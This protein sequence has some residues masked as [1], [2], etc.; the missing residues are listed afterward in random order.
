MMVVVV[1]PYRY[2]LSI[3]TLLV[4]PGY[5]LSHLLRLL[6]SLS[7]NSHPEN[8]LKT[9]L[10]KSNRSL[11]LS[12]SHLQVAH[13]LIRIPLD[14]LLISFF[15]S[16]GDFVQPVASASLGQ[17]YRAELVDGTIVA[18]KVSDDDMTGTHSFLT[19]I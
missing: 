19:V 18:V 12:D 3:L 11:H 7:L 17:V 13:I 14:S 2:S 8:D 5:H 4:P 15:R 10:S 6:L 1:I 9:S 16:R